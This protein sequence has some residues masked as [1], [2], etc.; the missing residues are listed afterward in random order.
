MARDMK[1][2]MDPPRCAD[3]MAHDSRFRRTSKPHGRV[4]AVTTDHVE[5]RA[6]ALTNGPIIDTISSMA[7]IQDLVETMRTSPTN[8]RFA[9]ACKVAEHFLGAPR[10]QGT[11]HRVYKMPWAGNPRV[12]LQEGNGGRAK[13]YQVQQLLAA[14]DQLAAQKRQQQHR[15]EPADD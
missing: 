12:N 14:I 6:R 3:R 2:D 15:P 10:Q 1:R 7:S 4:V 8:I 9:D 11:S 5:V 13:A